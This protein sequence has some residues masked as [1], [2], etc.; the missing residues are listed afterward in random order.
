MTNANTRTLEAPFALSADARSEFSAPFQVFSSGRIAIEASWAVPGRAAA[1]TSLR[2]ILIRPDGSEAARKDGRS[3]LGLEYFATDAEIDRLNAR[4]PARW[5]ARIIN[6]LAADRHEVSGKL[7]IIIPASNR[8]IEDTPF[9]LPG[10]GNAQEIPAHVPAP[11]RVIVE[12]EWQTDQSASDAALT[13]SLI[14][15]GTDKVYARRFGKSALRIE[16]QI[17]DQDFERG[18]RVI[19]RIQNDQAAKVRGRI[20]VLFT[21]SL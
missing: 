12:A 21:P 14:H 8:M 5:S 16:Q 1:Q 3:P 20:K 18:R 13:L 19:V 11:G 4:S 6:D 2:L 9:T 15:Q 7:R 10:A 17:T